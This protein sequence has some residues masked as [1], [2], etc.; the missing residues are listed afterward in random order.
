M[1]KLWGRRILALVADFI[2]VTLVI[3]ILSAL[4]YP[5]IAIVGLYGV[6]NLWLVFAAIIILLYFTYL[7]GNY[8]TTLGKNIMKIKVIADEGD[9]TYKKALIRSLSKILWF[10][11]IIDVLV[12]YVAGD[13]KIRYLDKIAGTNVIRKISK[14]EDNYNKLK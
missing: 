3:W 9:L 4:V 1:E 2:V 7:E 5:L 14:N 11:L 6:F 8:G 12:G 10:P 13:S